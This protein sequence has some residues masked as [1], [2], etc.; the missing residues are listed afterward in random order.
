MIPISPV[1][2][3]AQIASAYRSNGAAAADPA[4]G[5]FEAMVGHAV[6]SALGTMRGAERTT[7]AGLAGQTDVQSV[8]QALSNAEV[9][10]QAVVAVRDKVV[11]AYND[12][13]HMSV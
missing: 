12:I 4:A 6:G 10:L 9:T 11:G 8:V 13:M 1:A 2:S 7:A 5:G 3:A